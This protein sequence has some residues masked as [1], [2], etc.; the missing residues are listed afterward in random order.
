M[1]YTPKIELGSMRENVAH[2]EIEKM[3][4]LMRDNISAL[5]WVERWMVQ[6][7]FCA[8]VVRPQPAFRQLFHACLPGVPKSK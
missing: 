4:N 6:D 3:P 7:H 5:L 2:I 8:G 1:E